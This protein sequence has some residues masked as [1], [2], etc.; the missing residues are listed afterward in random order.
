MAEINIKFPINKINPCYRPYLDTDFSYEIYYG[1]AGSGKSYFIAQKLL[2]KCL[3]DPYFRLVFSRKHAVDVRKSQFLLFKDLISEYKLTPFFKVKE[4]QMDIVCCNGN[5]MM[6]AGMDN[7]E[8][9]KSIQ[10]PTHVWCEEITEFDYADFEQLDLRLRGDGEYRIQYLMSLNPINEEHW[11]KLELFD[12]PITSNDIKNVLRLKTTYLDNSFIDQAQYEEKLNR[13]SKHNQRVYKSG[14]WGLVRTGMEYFPNFDSEIHVGDPVYNPDVPIHLTLDMNVNPYMTMLAC[15]IQFVD[16]RAKVN[17]LNEYCL[18]HPLNKTKYVC[19]RFMRDYYGESALLYHHKAGVYYY[20]DATS[21]KNNTITTD[22]IKHD[23]DVL[24]TIL[25]PMLHNGSKR[26]GRYNPPV[27]K[28]KD[29]MDDLLLG[30]TPIDLSIAR[31]CKHTINDFNYLKEGADGKKFK[32][33]AEDTITGAK[34]Q[35]YGH[36]SDALEYML[37]KAF[38]SVYKQ[39]ERKKN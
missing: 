31:H 37:C 5:M 1:G 4:T 10:K 39:Y 12:K 16:G 18:P 19:Q 34:Y 6:S 38:E 9:I 29:F 24:E 23:Y 2:L 25:R 35:K 8:K 3:S 21:E 28:R 22:E 11:V 30:N 26:V 13:Q 27:L 7:P 17:V 32:E 20:G 36:T 15:Q 14:E 33:K